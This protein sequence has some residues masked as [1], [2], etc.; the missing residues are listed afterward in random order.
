MPLALEVVLL[1]V[2]AGVLLVEREEVLPDRLA[3][4]GLFD[5]VEAIASIRG[6]GFFFTG[7]A[8]RIC[9]MAV[10]CSSSVIR[11]SW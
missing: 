6:A 9:L 5:P 7:V 11:N 2:F 8:A 10:V 4:L 1:A 3:A